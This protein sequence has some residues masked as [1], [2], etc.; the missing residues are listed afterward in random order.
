MNPRLCN[1]WLDFNY[2]VSKYIILMLFWMAVL[3]H[4]KAM[5]PFQQPQNIY[6]HLI[7]NIWFAFANS[8]LI[9]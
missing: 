9:L 1:I 7:I 5:I 6:P 4:N 2:L 3:L 8:T